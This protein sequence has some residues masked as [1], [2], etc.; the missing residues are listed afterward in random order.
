MKKFT[1]LMFLFILFFGITKIYS[2]ELINT[3][4]KDFWI[5]FPPNYHNIESS[6]TSNYTDTLYIFIVATDTCSGTIFYK[7][8]YSKSFNK[9]FII[10]DPKQIYSFAL[11][12]YNFEL[13]GYNSSGVINPGQN[14]QCEQIA[15]QSFHIVST[16]DVTIYAHEQA[17][18]TSESM[19]CIPTDGLGTEYLVLTYNSDGSAN[20]SVINGESTPSQFVVVATQDSTTIKIN[21]STP[22]RAKGLI[23]Q[24]V[25]LNTGDVYL[26]QAQITTNNLNGDLTGTRVISDKPIALISGHQRTHLPIGEDAMSRD[27]LLEELPPISAWGHNAIVIPFA[28]SKYTY[29]AGSD[30][31]RVLSASDN[32]IITIDGIQAVTLNQSEMYE[33]DLTEPHYIEGSGPILIA[34]YKKSSQSNSTQQRGIGDPLMMIM[35]PIEQYDNFYRIANIQAYEEDD[36]TGNLNPVYS[37]HYI[38]IIIQDSSTNKVKIDGNFINS[39]FFKKVP[40]TQ[41]SYCFLQ[42]Q[43]GTHE[44]TAPTGFGLI[45]YGYGWANSYG[46]YGGMNLVKYDYTPPKLFADSSCYTINGV[47]S[48][49]TATDSHLFALDFPANDLNNVNITANNVFPVGV[50]YFSA[51]LSNIYLDGSFKVKAIDS[52]GLSNSL[53]YDIPGFTIAVKDFK[54][55]INPYQ[56]IDTI[57]TGKE[58]CYNIDL[59]NYGKFS[60]TLR[61]IYLKFQNSNDTLFT[62]IPLTLNNS[63]I[64]TLSIC[65]TFADTGSYNFDLIIEDTCTSRTVAN[66]QI[67]SFKDTKAPDIQMK[68]DPCNSVY[69]ISITEISKTDTGIEDF[70]IEKEENGKIQ[71]TKQTDSVLTFTFNVIDPREDASYKFKVIDSAGNEKDYEEIIPGFTLSFQTQSINPLD[72]NVLNF[73]DKVIGTRHSDTLWVKNYGKYEI[74]LN[75]IKIF[76][77]ILFSIPQSQFPFTI[78][79]AE[80]KPLIV[81]YK[82]TS[83]NNI[84][85]YDTLQISMN[86]IDQFIYLQGTP[87]VFDVPGTSKCQVPLKFTT[88]SIP[89]SLEVSLKNSIS[90]GIVQI[91]FNTE[92]NTQV[93]VALF[94]EFGTKRKELYMGVI[95]SGK[96]EKIFQIDDLQSS[97]YFIKINTDYG[98]A[99]FKII[100]L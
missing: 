82:P 16:R 50:A 35:P 13:R 98:T 72:S 74:T 44:L 2:Q 99:V 47:A 70:V 33:M 100:K 32:N 60:H 73:G 79:S 10:T 17:V 9:N 46:Y 23:P 7:D 34:Q 97:V 80:T 68:K 58:V 69:N 77:N 93:S 59:E 40:N 78:A 62:Y 81:I 3:K 53:Q 84:T 54:E 95:Q 76:Q 27:C 52:V 1:L 5:A 36:Y 49:S 92:F 39:S 43:Q 14:N 51:T 55:N 22:T 91:D 88:D 83:S 71:I 63:E 66:F 94:D 87:D 96:S 48:D 15:P 61:N 30:K 20:G 4:G 57:P 8:R 31:F 38:G 86:C 37:E 6:P 19:T 18:T 45:V 89:T 67:Y 12:Y 41:Y 65:K 11:P 29:S 24:T 26:V 90:N 56:I 64:R 75:S 21:P 28:Q 85:D 25:Q 42:V